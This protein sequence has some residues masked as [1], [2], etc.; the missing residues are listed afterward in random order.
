MKSALILAVGVIVLA[1]GILFTLQGANVVQWPRESFMINQ[2]EWTERGLV[3]A[4]I[5]LGLILTSFRIRK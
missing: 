4:L 1:F 2:H 3:V 5:G